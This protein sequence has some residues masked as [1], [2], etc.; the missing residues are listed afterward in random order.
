MYR[1]YESPAT[2]EEAL[3][4]KAEHGEDARVIAGGTDLLIE[5][6]RGVRKTSDGGDLGIID[7]THIPGLA[8][9]EERDG[10]I[11]LGPLVTHN[12]CVASPLIVGKAFPLARACWEVGAPQIRNRGTIAGNIIT[13]SPANDTL[14]PLLA[15]D[16]TVTVRSLAR[17][18]RK[19]AL[20]DFLLGFRQVDLQP[21][22]ILTDISFP[23]MTTQADGVFIKLGLR[24]A[25]A[26]SVLSVAVV[27]QRSDEQAGA[28]LQQARISLG[29]VAPMVVRAAAAEGYLA[30]K[31]LTDETI[32]EAARLALEA[33]SP[34][35]DIRS[36]AAYRLG[37]VETLVARALR[38]IRDGRTR[39]GWL[40]N[41]V[42]LWGSTDG[43]WPVDISHLTFDVSRL[44]SHE[45]SVNGQSIA[46]AGGMTLLDSLRTAGFVGVKEG[47]AEGECGACTVFLDS[48]A[49]MACM[50]PAE[51]AAASEVVTVEGLGNVA[52]LHP[53]QDAFV[54]SGGVQCGYCTPGFIMSAA[55]LLEERS[56]PTR[57][58]VQEALTGNLCRCT[59]YRKILDAVVLS[60]ETRGSVSQEA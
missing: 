60:G 42:M 50:V 20:S 2:L 24:R 49:V 45:S 10:T 17:G 26:I 47:C 27:I 4:L 8:E 16:A 40:S 22:E 19:L 56:H 13:A 57:D 36:S 38:Q 37:M 14:T 46:L 48:M 23:A 41:P 51:R 1:F 33:A 52:H 9:I 7:L 18:E 44:T 30:G 43:K 11:H 25:Q 34:I 5:L 6:D 21:D 32:G 54:Q 3:R 39:A 29:A 55:K 58:E 31:V 59:G 53:V 28:P 12:Q 35:D 15:L